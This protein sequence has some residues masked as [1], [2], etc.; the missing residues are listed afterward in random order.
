VVNGKRREVVPVFFEVAENEP[1]P[2]RL[3]A[4]RP[5]IR[6]AL[7]TAPAPVGRAVLIKAR[8]SVKVIAIIGAAR[9]EALGEA[10]QDG[11][12]GEVIGVRNV[13][14]GRTVHGRVQ[15]GGTVLVDY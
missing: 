2:A 4:E 6:T 1:A 12:A 14:S 7:Y 13:E 15:A 11:R 10:L 8:D 3:G 5:G 9:I